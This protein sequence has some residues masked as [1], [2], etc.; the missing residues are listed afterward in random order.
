MVET[1]S[2]AENATSKTAAAP[3]TAVTQAT[4]A[5]PARNIRKTLLPNGLT[6]LT[7]PMPHMRSVSMGVWI[8]TGSRDESS[9]QN[10]LSHFVEH[11]VFKGTTTRDAKQLAR[12]TDAIGGNLDA[13]TG[14]ETVCFNIKV[15]DSNVPAALDI[16]A[17]L[18]LNPRFEPTDVER[19]KSVILEEIKMDEDNPD[20]LVHEVHVAN[21]WKN[22][23]LAASI[24]GTTK[25]VSSFDEPAVRTFHYGAVLAGEHDVS[26][27][28]ATCS[29]RR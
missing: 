22:D 5:T 15:L 29:T 11:M 27:L 1:L 12:E 8:G 17:D 23:P 3:A 25:T 28:P 9:A 21:F 24:L 14:K 20:Y 19:E 26:P 4:A 16:L 18:V 2:V 10:G 7:E 13:F 6:V